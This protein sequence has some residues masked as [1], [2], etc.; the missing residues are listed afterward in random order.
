MDG[1]WVGKCIDATGSKHGR[2]IV[3][4]E[5]LRG[6]VRLER[7]FEVREREAAGKQVR[8]VPRAQLAF[9]VVAEVIVI[10]MPK[11]EHLLAGGRA[12][13]QLEHSRQGRESVPFGNQ[14]QRRDLTF[15]AEGELGGNDPGQGI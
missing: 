3:G 14:E 6:W 4:H 11:D 7:G 8:A 9:D 15:P 13:V 10:G 5:L 12:V 2:E 1:L